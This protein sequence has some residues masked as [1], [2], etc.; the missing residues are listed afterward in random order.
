[1]KLFYLKPF[2]HLRVV[3][4]QS[5]LKMSIYTSVMEINCLTCLKIYFNILIHAARVAE[6][7]F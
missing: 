5:K 1:M 3:G 4:P 7:I 6:R 2:E